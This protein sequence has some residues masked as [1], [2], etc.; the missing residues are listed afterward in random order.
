MTNFNEKI[1]CGTGHVLSVRDYFIYRSDSTRTFEQ[2]I[3]SDL[4]FRKNSYRLCI[5]YK[6]THPVENVAG[7][8]FMWDYASAMSD[9]VKVRIL[10]CDSNEDFS[11]FVYFGDPVFESIAGAIFI[12]D[13]YVV[14]YG[15]TWIEAVEIRGEHVVCKAYVCGRFVSEFRIPAETF[16]LFF[17]LKEN[18]PKQFAKPVKVETPQ[19][20]KI[21][22]AYEISCLMDANRLCSDLLS[23]LLRLNSVIDSH[24]VSNDVCDK[25]QVARKAVEDLAIELGISIRNIEDGI[26]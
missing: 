17:G 12:T 2:L 1:N 21:H 16:D 13:K 19:I 9:S 22:D 11:Y 18:F 24:Y 5:Q 6:D 3:D 26:Q 4:L 8:C 23:S 14:T 10:N 7:R 15:D 20:E 25:S